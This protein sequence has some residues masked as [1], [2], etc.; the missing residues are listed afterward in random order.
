M[1]NLGAKIETFTYGFKNQRDFK[2]AEEICTKLNVS[3]I[4]K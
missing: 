2:I 3:K 4:I 1:K